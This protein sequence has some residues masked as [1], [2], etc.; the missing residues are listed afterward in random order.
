MALD[1]PTDVLVKSAARKKIRNGVN[2][3]VDAIKLSLGPAG[4]SAILPRS[5]NRGPRHAD[6]GYFIAENVIPKDEHERQAAESFKEGIKKTNELAGDGTTTTGVISG[7]LINKIFSEMPDE[8]I[9]SAGKSAKKMVR[10]IR[11]EINEAKDLVIAEI[12]AKAKPIKTLTDLEKIALVAIGHEDEAAAKTIA[13]LVWEIG[14]DSTGA[15]V[16]N[17]IDVVEG[18]KG[19]L[20]TEVIKGMRFPAKVGHRAFVTKPER[21]EMEITDTPILITNHKIDNPF[22]MIRILESLKLS[23]LSV[24]A[25]DFSSSVIQSLAASFKNGV[26]CYPIKCPALRT[27]QLED[28]SAYTGATTIDKETGQK[29]ENVTTSD[30]GFASKIIVKDTENREDAVLLGGKGE[31]QRIGQGTRITE[32]CEI[33]K[34][35]IKESRNELTTIQLQKRIANLSSAVGVI[36][37]GATTA[38]A[39]GYLKLKIDDGTYSCKSALEEGYVKGGGLCLKEI[40]EKLPENILTNALK[41][42]YDQIQENA[43]GID[44]EKDIIDSAKVVRLEVV[45]AVDIAATIITTGISI[46]EIPEKTPGDGYADIAKAIRQ[47]AMYWAKD[48]GQLKASEDEAENDRNK[49]FERVMA[50]DKD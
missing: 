28:L 44:I 27:E 46:I 34:K 42:P 29:L 5:F 48:R 32:R 23:K 19:G 15:F 10:Q 43:G 3:V 14:R 38:K 33:L 30:L 8:S 21:F 47:Y 22:V 9:P 25:P 16:D 40:A 45:H 36:R 49:E 41:T 31:K 50:G 18:Y 26:F 12:K 2:A 1:R 39:A 20:E 7:A 37:V 17:H 4:Q 24:F 6:D 13:K 35:Q 11:Q